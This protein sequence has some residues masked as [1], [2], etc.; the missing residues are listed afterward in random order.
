MNIRLATEYDIPRIGDLLVQ[1]CNVHHNARPDLFRKDA[2]KYDDEE[3]AALLRR[4]DRPIF[5]AE[6]EKEGVVGYCFCILEEHDGESAMTKRKTLYIDD[7]CVDERCRGKH[8]GSALF[9]HARDYAAR[10]GCY[11]LTLNVWQG[12]DSAMAFYQSRGMK[13]QKIGMEIIL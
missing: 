13:T 1:V 5:V 4:E 10:I 2:R 9:D 6:D 11:H 7:L 3:L 8:V 12:N